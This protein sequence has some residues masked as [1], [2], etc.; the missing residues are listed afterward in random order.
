MWNEQQMQRIALRFLPKRL[1]G[2]IKIGIRKLCYFGF[3]R[4]C[5]VCNSWVKKFDSFGFRRRPDAQCP[6]CK[7]LERHRFVWI[8]FQKSTNLFDG[9]P[10]KML[11]FA[12]EPGLS[13][14]FQKIP[15]LDYVSADLDDKKA[16]VKMDISNIDFP[17]AS[18]DMVYCCHVLEH[19]ED[20][21]KA[22]REIFRVLKEDGQA[23]ILVPVTVEK[24]FEDLS[25][26]DPRQREEL[27]GQ[28]DHLRRYGVDFS[29]RLTDAGFKV[30][31]LFAPDILTKTQIDKFGRGLVYEKERIFVCR[32]K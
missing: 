3:S 31:V 15:S 1:H 4:Y 6:V 13:R 30:T 25:V 7:S 16:M 11:H 21:R 2:P 5:P 23:F 12:P 18:F 20:D 14:R 27:F 10:K 24:T 19:V 8:F 26:K 32:K 9:N 22:I 29:D 17:D 28:S